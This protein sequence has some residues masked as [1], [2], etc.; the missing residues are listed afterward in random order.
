MKRGLGSVASGE[1]GLRNLQFP[2]E[3]GISGR[4]LGREGEGGLAGH[5]FD[6]GDQ[7]RDV[8]QGKVR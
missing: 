8:F 2:A 6:G 4:S 5:P 7:G 3:G 1:A